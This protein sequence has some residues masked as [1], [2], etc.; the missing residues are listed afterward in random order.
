MSMASSNGQDL[1]KKMS[2]LLT[3][4]W[5]S[6]GSYHYW[7]GTSLGV[8]LSRCPPSRSYYCWIIF[9]PSLLVEGMKCSLY[10]IMFSLSLTHTGWIHTFSIGRL[11]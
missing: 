2:L 6:V 7:E 9:T 8:S 10:Y 11:V 1:G 5:L 4:L 3:I